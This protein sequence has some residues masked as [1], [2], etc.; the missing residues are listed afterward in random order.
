MHVLYASELDLSV[1]GIPP[2]FFTLTGYCASD[3]AFG[4]RPTFEVSNSP[5]NGNL[6]WYHPAGPVL[7]VG[8][9]LCK[10]VRF[11]MITCTMQM[12]KR[13][14]GLVL[15][16]MERIIRLRTVYTAFKVQ[17]LAALKSSSTQ[18]P[19]NMQGVLYI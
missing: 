18:C 17:H 7:S 1:P 4:V 16:G 8:H 3:A 6:A 2:H 9:Q 10:I 14:C 5:S 15:M 12:C 19:V 11:L 13:T